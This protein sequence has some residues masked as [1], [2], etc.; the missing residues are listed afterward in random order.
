MIAERF[1]VGLSFWICE[2]ISEELSLAN[3]N[4]AYQWTDNKVLKQLDS[5]QVS[6]LYA[7][8]Y[9][10]VALLIY[11]VISMATV[12]QGDIGGKDLTFKPKNAL[13]VVFSHQK[14]IE[15]NGIKCA[16]CHYQ[17][18]LKKGE[19]Y[20]LDMTR[21]LKGKF[22]GSCHNGD[23]AFDVNDQKSCRRCHGNRTG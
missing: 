10:M 19:Q 12:T 5:L 20:E 8:L 3:V 2:I 21:I 15:Y 7:K 17:L 16:D 23:K 9:I 6:D 11:L 14:H 22:C 4:I 1:S 13:P 18:F